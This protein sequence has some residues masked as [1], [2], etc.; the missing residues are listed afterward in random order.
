MTTMHH[1]ALEVDAGNP[2]WAVIMRLQACIDAMAGMRHTIRPEGDSLA[3]ALSVA[4]AQAMDEVADMAQA[5][6]AAADAEP[7]PAPEPAPAA[8]TATKKAR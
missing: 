3:G 2:M 5:M 7:P 6:Q 4:L 1:P 8:K